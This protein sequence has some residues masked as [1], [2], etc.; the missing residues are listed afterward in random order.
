MCI[1]NE[2][3]LSRRLTELDPVK[4]IINSATNNFYIKIIAWRTLCDKTKS[5]LSLSLY[6]EV[7][8]MLFAGSG[9]HTAILTNYVRVERLV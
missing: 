9:A 6:R 3:A 4:V 8:D 7:N 5:R 2:K 1:W